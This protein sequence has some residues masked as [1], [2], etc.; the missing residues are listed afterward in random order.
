MYSVDFYK[1]LSLKK[2]KLETGMFLIEGE[3]AVSQICVSYPDAIAEIACTEIYA[4]KYME[5]PQKIVDE[6]QF[7]KFSSVK[8]PQ[9]IAAIIRI[10][11]GVYNSKLPVNPGER[12]L[13]LDS[14]QDPGNTGTLIRSAAAFGFDGV[15]LSDK[16]AD[17]FSS[18]VV[19]ST[20]GSILSLWIR[21]T[22]DYLSLCVKLKTD[23]FKFASA[24]QRGAE[25]PDVLKDICPFVL[26]LGNEASGLSSGI[27]NITDVFIGISMDSSRVESLNVAVSGAICMYS[28]YRK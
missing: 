25:P 26:A 21:K 1:K 13:L 22:R 2:V 27:R 17:P 16:C 20:A 3:R 5:F 24:D 11:Q 6:N 28:A 7:K 14:V 19:Q 23:G 4:D 8:T 12:I 18:K 15:V 9:G 10:P